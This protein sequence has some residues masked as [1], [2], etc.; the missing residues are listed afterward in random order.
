MEYASGGDLQSLI[1]TQ[2]QKRLYLAEKDIWAYAWQM[3]MGILHIHNRGI[4]HRDIK[5]LN[6]ML[7]G[8]GN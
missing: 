3:C 2:K 6:I 1:L 4:I 7:A 8:Q 5:C